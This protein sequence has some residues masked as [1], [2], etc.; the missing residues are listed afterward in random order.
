MSNDL[1]WPFYYNI[2]ILNDKKN[3]MKWSI[4]FVLPCMSLQS[5]Q[6]HDVVSIEIANMIGQ[7]WHNDREEL[8]STQS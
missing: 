7:I 3:K 4:I 8:S 6:K 1:N 5:T 2:Y